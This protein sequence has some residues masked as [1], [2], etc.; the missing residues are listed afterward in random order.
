MLGEHTRHCCWLQPTVAGESSSEAL[1]LPLNSD[2]MLRV[3]SDHGRKYGN[4]ACI[5][6][7][8]EGFK[9]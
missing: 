2:A 3:V 4:L 7:D 1:K 6:E 9:R 5:P 8:L